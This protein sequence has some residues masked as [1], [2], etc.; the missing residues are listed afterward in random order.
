MGQRSAKRRKSQRRRLELMSALKGFAGNMRWS[1]LG[2]AGAFYSC[3]DAGV[4]NLFQGLNQPFGL[5]WWTRYEHQTIIIQNKWCVCELKWNCG[6]WK[7]YKFSIF[8]SKV[9]RIQCNKSLFYSPPHYRLLLFVGEKFSVPK[10][11]ST[12]SMTSLKHH[13]RSLLMKALF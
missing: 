11:P 4:R 7:G 10:S 3:F 13:Y 1:V 6:L 12:Q 5:I 9:C 8:T 2:R